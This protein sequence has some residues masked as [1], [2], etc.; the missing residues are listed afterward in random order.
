[1]Y[2]RELAGG[3]RT[4]QQVAD[5][6]GVTRAAVC[7]YM[8]IINRLPTELVEALE[9]QTGSTPVRGFSVKRLLRIARLSGDAAQRAAVADVLAGG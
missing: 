9:A 2:E 3:R 1:V 8:T 5:R 4:Y 7:Q 6:F